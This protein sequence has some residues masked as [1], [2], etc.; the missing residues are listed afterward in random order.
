MMILLIND[1]DYTLASLNKLLFCVCYEK[2]CFVYIMGGKNTCVK[3]GKMIIKIYEML[4]Y[5][6]GTENFRYSTKF[7][8]SF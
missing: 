3:L 8:Q 1:S 4:K 7:Q 5:P 6:V 2:N